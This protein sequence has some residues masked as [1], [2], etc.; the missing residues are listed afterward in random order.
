MEKKILVAVDDS[1]HTVNTVNYLSTLFAA[2]GEVKLDLLYLVSSGQSAVDAAWQGPEDEI[3]QL[4]PDARNRR[5]RAEECVKKAARRLGRNG[6][7]AE[8]INCRVL[9]ATTGVAAGIIAAAKKGIYDAVVIGRRGLS[10]LE[11]IM[12]G[13]VSTEVIDKCHEVPIWVVDGEVNSNHFLI[14]VDGSFQSLL[15]A[16][17][18]GH[19]LGDHPI[20]EITLFHSSAMFTAGHATAP[21]NFYESFG[22]DWCEEHLSRPDSTFHGP[23]QILV[24]HGFDRHRIKWLHT[25]RGI[26]PSRQ[27]IRQVIMNK[28]GTIVIGR[29]SGHI[30]KG[31]FRGISDRVLLMADKVAVWVVG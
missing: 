14:P 29:R 28:Q 5:D 23:R 12:L 8:R 4:Q 21:R 7:A 15:A 9:P 20:A 30:N 11:E 26:E 2:A 31:I 6:I 25:F 19:I 18:L 27:I 16:D 22:R 10:K 17:H 1:T 24:D 3:A 13:S